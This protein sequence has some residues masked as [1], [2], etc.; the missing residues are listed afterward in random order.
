AYNIICLLVGSDPEKFND[1]AEE[2]GLPEDRRE[3]CIGDYSNA[4]WSWDKVL[5]PHLRKADQK[6]QKVEVFYGDAKNPL[7]L[8]QTAFRATG[9]M[10]RSGGYMVDRYVWRTP[11]KMEFKTCGE[12]NAN[13]DSQTHTL[14]L[15]YEM[16][17]DFVQLYKTY[18]EQPVAALIPPAG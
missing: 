16:A 12:I 18:G 7:D 9:V 4:S 15:C 3:S 14:T 1:L 11:F 6:P 17:E 10:E 2:T 8:V 5:E 13:F